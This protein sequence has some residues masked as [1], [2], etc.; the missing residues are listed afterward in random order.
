M[1]RLLLFLYKSKPFLR[2]YLYS[3]LLHVTLAIRQCNLMLRFFPFS[4]RF[5][6]LRLY[7]QEQAI[8]LFLLF[9][10][11]QVLLLLKLYQLHNFLSILYLLVSK[12]LPKLDS[13]YQVLKN[14]CKFLSLSLVLILPNGSL[15]QNYTNFLL[16][17]V[18]GLKFPYFMNFMKFLGMRFLKLA[19]WIIGL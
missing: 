12:F 18:A 11:I 13:F 5:F 2:P 7:I 6:Q 3:S 14:F 19:E 4:S 10:L 16:I 17:S 8:H 9:Q 15:S 1:L